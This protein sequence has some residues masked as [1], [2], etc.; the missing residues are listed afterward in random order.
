MWYTVPAASTQVVSGCY[1]DY[2][3]LSREDRL[4]S[5]CV[6]FSRRRFDSPGTAAYLTEKQVA[7][8][9][10]VTGV[11]KTYTFDATM[12]LTMKIVTLISVS[13]KS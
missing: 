3:L 8:A 7:R 13:M 12:P 10:Q 11:F 2:A 5:Q 1:C 4:I 9:A 6:R